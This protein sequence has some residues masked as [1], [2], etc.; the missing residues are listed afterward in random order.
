MKL[1]KK[2]WLLFLAL[3]VLSIII[4]Y[5][6]QAIK[7]ASF[8]HDSS[9][10]T[11]E[12]C[13]WLLWGITVVL[14][15]ALC[16]YAWDYFKPPKFPQLVLPLALIL[17]AA[18]G[19]GIDFYRQYSDHQAFF[20]NS[21]VVFN[22]VV[23]DKYQDGDDN[24]LV[25]NNEESNWSASLYCSDSEAAL[26]QEGDIIGVISIKYLKHQPDIGYIEYLD[27]YIQREGGFYDLTG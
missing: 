24:I 27:G 6:T 4:Y 12:V 9:L 1:S 26:L 5:L 22:A 21:G 3:L 17:I 25:I 14:L 18:I 7:T 10:E 19:I 2:V 13:V 20:I 16:Y 11:Y 8:I 15:I 23:V